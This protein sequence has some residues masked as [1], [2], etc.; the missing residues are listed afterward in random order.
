MARNYAV[1]C[2]HRNLS[3]SSSD[4]GGYQIWCVTKMSVSADSLGWTASELRIAIGR[5][6]LASSKPLSAADLELAVS[7]HQSN[8][9]KEAERMATAG[10]IQRGIPR[11]GAPRRRGPKPEAFDMSS[12][13]R[14]RASRDLARAVPPGLLQQGQEIVTASVGQGQ[15]VDLLEVLNSAE[16]TTR[17]AWV[18]ML[19]EELLV[20][21]DGPSA[22]EPALELQAVLEAADISS[23]RMA[24]SRVVSGHE[25]VR[26]G[27]KAIR[28]VERTRA[29]RR[30]RR[31]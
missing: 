9:K 30:A 6:M 22:A 10:L 8:I 29:A 7:A 1:G 17:A 13:Q 24:V 5:A 2:G 4:I 27:Q 18:A 26:D 14:K 11:P 19:G 31:E 25:W 28:A 20:A 23:R 15:T 12:A 3:L 21:Y 16:A